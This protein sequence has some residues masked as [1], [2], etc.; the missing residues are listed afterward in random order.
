MRVF[1]TVFCRRFDLGQPKRHILEHGLARHPNSS[2]L[3]M[4]LGASAFLLDDLELQQKEEARIRRA[5]E[6]TENERQLRLDAA[7]V[8]RN[9]GGYYHSA[10]RY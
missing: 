9:I 7:L 10:Y 6:I 1:R 4:L 2:Q 3:N 8:Y 5:F